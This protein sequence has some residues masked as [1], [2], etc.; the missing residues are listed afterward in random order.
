M[1]KSIRVCNTGR[2]KD[3][4]RTRAFGLTPWSG[5]R[6]SIKLASNPR[7][8]R[9]RRKTEPWQFAGYNFSSA[10]QCTAYNAAY[11]RS[12]ADPEGFWG[13]AAASLTWHR[14]WDAVLDHSNPPFTRWFPGGKLNVCYN[15]VDRHVDIGLGERVAVIHDS[16]VTSSVRKITY[17]ELH[18]E[19]CRMAAAL[20]AMGVHRGDTLLIYM[21]M[22]PEAIVTMLACARLGAIHSLVFGGFAARELAVRITH[23]QPKVIVTA[24]CGVEPGRVVQYQPV[25]E[26][27]LQLSTV[28]APKCIVFQR[29]QFARSK[30]VEGRD[31]SWDEAVT[32]APDR[33]IDCEPVD[34]Q[35]PLYILYTSGTT[36]DPKGVVRPC[37][38]HAVMLD[39]SMR[40]VY[41]MED[42][43]T[44]W[45]ASDLGWVVGHSYICYAPLLRGLTSVIFEGKPVGTPDPGTYFRVISQ[46]GVR[47]MFTAPTALRAIRKEDPAGKFAN[48][49]DLSRLRCV[50]LAGEHCDFDTMQ[51]ARQAFGVEVL[52]NWWQTESGSPMTCVCTG[53]STETNVPKNSSGRPIPGWKFGVIKDD[54]TEA[55]PGE[56]GRIVAEQPLPPGFMST[57]Y[58]NEKQF[59]NVYFTKYPG[60]Y[61]TMDA[62]YVD[63][64]GFLYIMSRDDDVINVAG[65]RISTKALEEALLNHPALIECAVIGVPDALKGEIPVGLYVLKK[66][67]DKS[68]SEIAREL[69]DT[70]RRLIGPVAAF[71]TAIRIDALPKTRSGKIA[72][73]TI[74]DLAKNRAVKIPSTIED[75]SVYA[76]IKKA[77]QQHGFAT[78]APD[79]VH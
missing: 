36:G 30:L 66:A 51:W 59:V 48:K 47:G 77:L 6:D 65:H 28:E 26:E 74:A 3:L 34:S 52:D 11:Q 41:G 79:P 67:T 45:A 42:G 44:W 15:A 18:A 40:N 20:R 31:V 75:S 43:D 64:D 17:R 50:F 68:D 21:P 54:G 63:G 10:L 39:W 46:H 35:H 13:E 12:L 71:K 76:G 38:G 62:G 14:K 27:A 9:I 58:K 78:E 60:M 32:L 24:N 37:G 1:L 16:P 57:L 56:M 53:L 72:R 69:V 61:D 70:V 2:M 29:P 55:Q 4:G 33:P 49:Y 8:S 7:F 19:V 73:K 5:Q 23:C 25:I 22:I